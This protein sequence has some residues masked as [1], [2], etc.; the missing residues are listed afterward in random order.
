MK[1]LMTCCIVSFLMTGVASA[2]FSGSGSGFTIPGSGMASSDILAP[3]VGPVVDVTVELETF[4]HNWIGDLTVTLT[5]PD[6][7]SMDLMLRT[8][9]PFGGGGGGGDSSNVGGDYIFADGGSDWWAA[10]D[11]AGLT[12][13]I[14]ED[15][16]EATTTGGTVESFATTFGGGASEGTWTLTI[17]D[18]TGGTQGSISGWT[19]NLTTIPEPGAMALFAVAG[20]GLVVCRRRRL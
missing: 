10:A 20:L 1:R 19:L 12:D 4:T 9:D 14:P 2:D 11:A 3:H 15:T 8:G 17:A 13:I 5:S 16:Y 18:A 6:G 7:V